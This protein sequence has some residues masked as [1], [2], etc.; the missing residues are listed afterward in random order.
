MSTLVTNI[1]ELVT[2]DPDA[3]DPLGIV[4]RAALVVDGATV[5]WVGRGAGAPAPH[6]GPT[7]A[8]ARCPA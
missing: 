8:P 3:D 2:N 1:G 6:G 7:V 5:A 4:E